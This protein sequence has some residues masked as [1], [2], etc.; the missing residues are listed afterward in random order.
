MFNCAIHCTTILD[1]F[2]HAV[3]HTHDV[4]INFSFLKS[5]GNYIE[6]IRLLGHSPFDVYWTSVG[7]SEPQMWLIV[8]GH[9][10]VWLKSQLHNMGQEILY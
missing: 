9:L 10:L 6:L 7:P 4:Q 8:E 2:A 5:T 1:P 3:Y